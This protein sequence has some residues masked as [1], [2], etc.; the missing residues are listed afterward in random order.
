MALRPQRGDTT[1]ERVHRMDTTS[2]SFA[3]RLRFTTTAV[4]VV[5]VP[6]AAHAQQS[7]DV[8][9]APVVAEDGPPTAPL[10]GY[11]AETTAT[12][13]KTATPLAEVPQSITVIGR[14]EMEARGVDKVD[15]A[16]RYVA[17]VTTQ[18]FG[19]DS[20]TNWMF[21]RGFQATQTG[22]YQDGLQNYGYAFG[23]F[24]TD[25]YMLE[26]IEVLRGASS[27]LYGG[28]SAG[29][30]VNHVRKRPTGGRLREADVTVQDTGWVT[31]GIDVGD[32]VDEAFA[33]RIT[34]L[35]AAGDRATD[36]AD[37][38]RGIV[39]P[40]LEWTPNDRTTVAS[41]CPTPAPWSMRP[42]VVSRAR[43]ISPSRTS[44]RTCVG[45]TRPDINWNTAST[46]A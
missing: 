39:A 32:R 30:I 20:D 18:P 9:R 10:A 15:E 28:A 34:A 14:E 8:A 26:R 35:T 29:G 22:I 13:T 3:D 37:G 6:M 23:S 7:D 44:T 19:A 45:S 33:Y 46:M 31:T 25:P 38:F 27:A 2:T 40:A 21:I 41:S 1:T 12:G 16:L 42:S 5:L 4:L 17:G 24:F 43:P 11:V 36:F